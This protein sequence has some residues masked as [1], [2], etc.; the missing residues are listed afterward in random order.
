VPLREHFIYT[1]PPGFVQYHAQDA[2]IA[3]VED[4]HHPSGEVGILQAGGR[5]HQMGGE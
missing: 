3:V 5:H 2:M 1:H 4:Q